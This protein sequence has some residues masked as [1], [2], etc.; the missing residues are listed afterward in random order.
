M[1]DTAAGFSTQLAEPGALMQGVNSTIA[2]LITLTRETEAED[3][4]AAKFVRER[5]ELASLD[6]QPAAA[7]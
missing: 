3:R 4:A 2:S 1:G 5:A 6:G 7:S